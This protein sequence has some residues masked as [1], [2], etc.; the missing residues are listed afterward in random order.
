MAVDLARPRADGEHR[1][2][3]E[4]VEA[5]ASRR[6]VGLGVAGS[7]VD[8]VELGVVR[9]GAPRRRPAVEVRVAVGGPRLVAG[10]AGA[11]DGVA[12]PQLLAGGGVP[13]VEEAAGGRLAPGHPRDEDPVGDHGGA[14]RVVALRP[15]GELLVPQLLAG[16]HVEGE[17]VVVDGDPE[18]P[19]LVDHRAA[20]V[21]AAAPASPLL[22][23]DRGAPDLPPRLE[24]D[25]ERPASVDGVEDPVVDGRRRELARLVHQ[26]RAPDGH[27]P[28]DV[29]LVDLVEGAV[30]LA[31]VPHAVDEHVLG[32]PRV[33][34]QVFRRLGQSPDPAPSPRRSASS[35]VVFFMIDLPSTR[36][37]RTSAGRG[38]PRRG[39]RHCP[40]RVSAIIRGR[41]GTVQRRPEGAGLAT[42]GAPR[43]AVTPRWVG[44]RPS[45]KATG[46]R[47]SV[48]TE[49]PRAGPGGR[50]PSITP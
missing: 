11:G 24:V 29:R 10:L 46:C 36:G 39:R 42:S 40:A 7:P 6:V 35:P 16:L 32:G 41:A 43:T 23:D 33:V 21:E 27:E 20:P 13:A 8:E 30:A 3:V 34:D 22:E 37:R 5:A 31:V 47:H 14:R 48:A 28:V 44:G 17:D 12:A 49:A 1:R 19:A 18:E 45:R 25:G 4:A 2:R 26:A 50:S 9:A 15:V 38:D